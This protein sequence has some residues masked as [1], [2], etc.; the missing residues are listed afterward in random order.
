MSLLRAAADHLAGRKAEP[1]IQSR[2]STTT[3]AQIDTSSGI[4]PSNY[5]IWL[6]TF[7]FL[8][9]FRRRFFEIYDVYGLNFIR[10]LLSWSVLELISWFYIF[11]SIP[12]DITTPKIKFYEAFIVFSYLTI[13]LV[14]YDP[15]NFGLLL[16]AYL[17][18]RFGWNKDFRVSVI[19]LL[20][21]TFLP[22]TSGGPFSVLHE[23]SAQ[24][25]AIIVAYFVKLTG[26]P[27][28]ISQTILMTPG[29]DHGIDIYAG[30]AS[31][32]NLGLIVGTFLIIVMGRRGKLH[33]SD[34]LWLVFLLLGVFII[35]WLRL[36]AMLLTRGGYDYW[37]NGD[38][39]SIV[40]LADT[41]LV[42]LL[43]GA[44]IWTQRKKVLG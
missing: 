34:A 30:C 39:V 7:L 44:A 20:L 12:R 33:G 40:S 16:F 17:A 26:H 42:L 37:H 36:S 8:T 18:L 13:V 21:V 41:L 10:L 11:K 32:V 2:V 38:G 28:T 15:R 4:E 19:C 31:T 27:V 6:I 43:S 23:K 29:A 5:V 1:D 24:L 9:I 25:D 3:H 14:L 22:F 35:N